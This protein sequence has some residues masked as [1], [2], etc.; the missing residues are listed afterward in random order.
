MEKK[1]PPY[2]ALPFIG[3]NKPVYFWK[4]RSRRKYEKRIP[5]CDERAM[6]ASLLWTGVSLPLACR[7][8]HGDSHAAKLITHRSSQ[9]KR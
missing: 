1:L 3:V 7:K 6:G 8:R 4:K 2:G 5:L 9:A